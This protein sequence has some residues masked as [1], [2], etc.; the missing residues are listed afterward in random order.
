VYG[1]GNIVVVTGFVTGAADRLDFLTAGPTP[2][3]AGTSLVLHVGAADTLRQQ[4]AATADGLAARSV[5]AFEWAGSTYLVVAPSE[6]S[7]TGP[8]GL[9]S[10]HVFELAGVSG[11]TSV[12]T[13]ADGHVTV[14]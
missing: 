1:A 6:P 9:A 7:A 13:T 11:A 4:L 5:A 14:V 10:D 8:Y 12:R 2:A 3:V